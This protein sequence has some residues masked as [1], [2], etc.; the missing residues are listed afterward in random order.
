MNNNY[1]QPNEDIIKKIYTLADKLGN[2]ET[3]Y[4]RFAILN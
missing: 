4:A 3:C 2:C 1:Y